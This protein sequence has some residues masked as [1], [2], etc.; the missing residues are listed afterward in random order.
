[1]SSGWMQQHGWGNVKNEI[2]STKRLL[3]FPSLAMAF[4]KTAIRG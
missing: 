4:P 3:P 1:M 2:I